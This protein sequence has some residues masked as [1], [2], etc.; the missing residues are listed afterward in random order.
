VSDLDETLEQRGKVY[1]DFADVSH[2][3]Q[4]IKAAMRA[5]P[6]WPRLVSC[7]RESLE[8]IANK[9]GRIL[10]GNPQYKDSWH[11]I[12]GYAQLVFRYLEANDD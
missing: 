10:E 9:L 2:R 4:T 3:A 6:G 7:Q 8:M 5:S 12:A 1:G 11:D